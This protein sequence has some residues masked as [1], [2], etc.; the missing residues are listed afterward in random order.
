MEF[1]DR[2][3]KILLVT[4]V[5]VLAFVAYKRTYNTTGPSSVVTSV[6]QKSEGTSIVAKNDVEQIV[7][8]FILDN[9][10]VIIESIERMQQRKLD[11]MNAQIN[12]VIKAKK[13][14]LEG[15]KMSPV[16]GDGNISLI[17]FYDVNCTYC[18]KANAVID[19][20][21]N[22]NKDIKV[23]YKPVPMLGES[24][25]YATK[26]EL[27][28]YKLFPEKFGAVHGALMSQKIS[29]RDDIVM[30]LEKNSINVNSLESEFDGV[31]MVTYLKN[32]AALILDL[33]IQGVPNFIIGGEL[34][35]GYMDQARMQA[36]IDNIKN[37]MEKAKGSESDIQPSDVPASEASSSDKKTNDDMNKDANQKPA[38]E[39]KAK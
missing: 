35:Q 36:I 28:V 4:L 30:I 14:E 24:S 34:Y 5:F 13:D 32:S 38:L 23:I 3:G 20:L 37:K 25:N 26:I 27:A 12:D 7:R 19:N 17:M 8:Q 2:I 31:D 11:E 22:D 1:R 29:S 16:A 10:G 9:P 6:E 21:I 33:K 39:K 15:E 18:K